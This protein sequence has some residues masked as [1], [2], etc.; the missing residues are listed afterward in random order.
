MTQSIKFVNESDIINCSRAVVSAGV[1]PTRIVLRELI[2]DKK[3]VTHIESL[4]IVSECGTNGA[5]VCCEVQFRHNSFEHGNYFEFGS[6]WSR[7]RDE[8]FKIASKDFED[9]CR[10][11]L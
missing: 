8:A 1:L 5:G 6:G 7:T 11:H 10:T 3:F 9:R 2:Q 4:V